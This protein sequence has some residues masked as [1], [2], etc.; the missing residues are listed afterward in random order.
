MP[1]DFWHLGLISLLFPNAKIIHTMRDSRDVCLSIY[2]QRMSL[3]MTFTTDLQELGEYYLIY[4]NLMQY[5]HKTLDIPVL[6]IQYE[7]LVDHQESTTRQLLDFCGLEWNDSCLEFYKNK[8][9]VNTPSY[10]QVRQPLYKKSVAR[11][12][13]YESSLEPLFKV[14]NGTG[15]YP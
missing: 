3:N 1:F 9:D 5:W 6:D 14:L 4:D 11:W 2:F 10:D 8:R 7:Q 13:H 15:Y 12:K